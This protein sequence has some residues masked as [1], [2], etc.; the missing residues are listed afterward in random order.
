MYFLE[1]MVVGPD[2]TS[3]VTQH[4][5]RNRSNGL[6]RSYLYCLAVMATLCV[7]VCVMGHL[8]DTKKSHDLVDTSTSCG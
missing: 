6:K 2:R 8:P 1:P 5:S 4:S 3:K 7:C